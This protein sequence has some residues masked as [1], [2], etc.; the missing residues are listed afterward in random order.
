MKKYL[1]VLVSILALVLFTACNKDKNKTEN[2]TSIDRY[3]VRYEVS[4]SS[5]YTGTLHVNVNTEN[6]IKTFEVSSKLFSETFGPVDYGFQTSVSASFGGYSGTLS[7]SIYV[8][9]NN[10]PFVLK[11]TGGSTAEY[12]IDF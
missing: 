3:Y 9:K 12:T 10:D 11:A 2:S 8:C 1:L 5:V 6:G 4:V 7:S